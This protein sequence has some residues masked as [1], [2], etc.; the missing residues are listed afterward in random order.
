MTDFKFVPD[1]KKANYEYAVSAC[2]CGFNCRYDGNTK[3]VPKI[4]EL[5]DAGRAILVCP[6][7]M[8]GLEIPR[9]A[10][11]IIGDKV[12][13]KN[14]RDNTLKFNKGA[15]KAL[16]LCKKYGVKKAI[17]KQNSPSCGSRHIYDGTFSGTLTEGMGIAARLLSEN[18][19]EVT[20]EK[21]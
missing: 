2:L 9:A 8:G 19:I 18:G 12:I 15:E 14:G 6:E 20:G 10:S 11:E 3:S 4:K 7:V 13:D 5:Y 21:N 1:E 17:L 16:E